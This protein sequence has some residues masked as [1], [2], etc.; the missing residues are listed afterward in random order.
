LE[1]KHERQRPAIPGIV[2]MSFGIIMVVLYI[3]LGTTIIFKAA[4]IPNIPQSYAQIFGVMLIFYG[5]FRG[6][7]VYRKHTSPD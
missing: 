1:E 4:Q 7:K 2:S 3:T 5:A 6:Y